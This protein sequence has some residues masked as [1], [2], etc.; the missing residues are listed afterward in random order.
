MKNKA[1]LIG[2]ILVSAALAGCQSSSGPEASVTKL[3]APYSNGPTTQ[4][5]VK[6]PTSLPGNS[7][8]PQAVTETEAIKVTLPKGN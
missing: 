6:G 1:V 5:G 2:L 4:P 8:S 7:S 3:Q